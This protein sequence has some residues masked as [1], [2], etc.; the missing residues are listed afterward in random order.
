[1]ELNVY[2]IVKGVVMTEKSGQQYNKQGRVTLVVNKKANKV[3]VR[4][5][6]EKIW[7]VKVDAVHV[8]NIPGKVK[9]FGRRPYYA[10]GKKKAI[11]TLKPG[12]TIDFPGQFES[13]GSS[14]EV[15]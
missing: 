8:I 5:A 14:G 13:I 1:M 4:Q 10:P 2:D 15:K 7:N 3:V 9:N 11:I 12:Y 6:V